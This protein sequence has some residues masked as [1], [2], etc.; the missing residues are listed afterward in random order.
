MSIFPIP[1]SSSSGYRVES[2]SDLIP[3]LED[4]FRQDVPSIIDCPVD[5]GENVKLTEHLKD[6]YE[7]HVRE[8]FPH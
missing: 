3:M 8:L 4:A 7:S 2:A 1:I 6:V 5:Y